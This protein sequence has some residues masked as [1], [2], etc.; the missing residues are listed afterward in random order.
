M[1]AQSLIASRRHLVIVLLII[2]TI[3]LLG[4]AQ[5]ESLGRM[6]ADG[7]SHVIP[8][9]V[10]I[11]LQL[12]WVRYIHIGMHAHGHSLAELTDGRWLSPRAA[13]VDVGY[14]ALGFAA[15]RSIAAFLEVAMGNYHANTA[16][17]L[18]HGVAESLL[19]VLVSVTAGICEEIVYRG[20]LQRQ[21]TALSGSVAGGIVLQAIAFGVS[22]GYQ[23]IQPMAVA[24][25][26]GLV[27]GI[28]ARWRG[29]IRASALAHAAT[30][31]VGGLTRF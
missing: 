19:W 2:T 16:F 8:Y 10:L 12:L 28:L 18:P 17:L 7:T 25:A 29:N 11:G 20:Y 14:A 15:A 30:D 3:T 24:G 26:Y 22:H 13:I 4:M 6:P 31:I 9:L 27:L 1:M 21:L 5:T 23:G